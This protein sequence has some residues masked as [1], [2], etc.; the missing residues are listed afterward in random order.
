MGMAGSKKDRKIPLAKASR[1][2]T[3][4]LWL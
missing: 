2:V 4:F 3:G 1:P